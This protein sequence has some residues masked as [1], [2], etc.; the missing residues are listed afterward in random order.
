MNTYTFVFIIIAIAVLAACFCLHCY[1]NKKEAEET[2]AKQRK[3]IQ[4]LEDREESIHNQI[5]CVY[6]HVFPGSQVNITVG[7]KLSLIKDRFTALHKD[8]KDLSDAC[9]HNS[10]KLGHAYSVIEETKR[11]IGHPGIEDKQ[12]PQV[13]GGVLHDLQT[14]LKNA[15]QKLSNAEVY[16]ASKDSTIRTHEEWLRGAQEDLKHARELLNDRQER[17]RKLAKEIDGYAKD[18]RKLTERANTL[19]HQLNQLRKKPIK[20]QAAINKARKASIKKK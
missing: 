11:A 1:L 2:Q 18:R 5:S 12:L 13:A 19:E 10:G 3:H 16:L 15:E 4:Q 14:R 9:R 6:G 20:S 8:Q 7:T 17:I